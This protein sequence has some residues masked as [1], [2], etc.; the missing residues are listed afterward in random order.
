MT[1]AK[2]FPLNIM[3]ELLPLEVY[4]YSH[5]WYHFTINIQTGRSSESPGQTVNPIALRTA[6]TQVLAV[7]SATR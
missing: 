7:L 2:L 3:A 1:T 4:L 5:Y 6:K